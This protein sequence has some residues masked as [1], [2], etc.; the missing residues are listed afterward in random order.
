MV[1]QNPDILKQS[2]FEVHGQ[3]NTVK[4]RKKNQQDVSVV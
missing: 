3:K 1:W 4:K 2:F